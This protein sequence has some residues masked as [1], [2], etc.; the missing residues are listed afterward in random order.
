MRILQITSAIVAVGLSGCASGRIPIGYDDCSDFSTAAV[1]AY[2]TPSNIK[3]MTVLEPLGGNVHVVA[4]GSV[5]GLQFGAG[6]PIFMMKVEDGR[7][8]GFNKAVVRA[9]TIGKAADRRIL[10]WDSKAEYPVKEIEIPASDPEGVS[11]N[12]EVTSTNG[13]QIIAMGIV[14]APA[15]SA[16][17]CVSGKAPLGGQKSR[18]VTSLVKSLKSRR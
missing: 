7:V 1:Q 14:G 9:T 10:F 8:M 6:L 13:N 2:P 4:N 15:I 12:Y 3:G 5:H 16:V 17:A 11:R 18:S